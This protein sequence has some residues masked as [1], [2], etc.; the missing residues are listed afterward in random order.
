MHTYRRP[1]TQYVQHENAGDR[2]T[3]QVLSLLCEGMSLRATAR[4]T[5]IAYNT[6]CK[7][8]VDA[9]K[10][11]SDFQDTLYANL[12]CKRIEA[13]EIWAFVGAKEKHATDRR[14]RASATCGR[15]RLS[16][17]KRS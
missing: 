16:T 15:R 17:R 1:L 5:D 13:D 11:L 12:P 7:L 2:P 9:G 8:L 3:R 14:L 6:A 10:A 4:V